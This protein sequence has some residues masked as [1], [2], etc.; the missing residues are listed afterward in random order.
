MPAPTAKRR[1]EFCTGTLDTRRQTLRFRILKCTAVI[2]IHNVDV[3]KN[4]N[5]GTI[6][7][8]AGL[9]LSPPVAHPIS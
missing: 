2:I 5:G 1:H 6:K 3:Q 9:K 8:F 4:K 7:P